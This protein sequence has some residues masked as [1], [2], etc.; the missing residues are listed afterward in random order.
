MT[1]N[2]QFLGWSPA[3]L[4]N[5]VLS[6]SAERS[7]IGQHDIALWRGTDGIARAWENRCPHRGMRLSFGIVRENTLT[8]LYHG[9]R[10]KGDGA[11]D[12]IP[13]HPDLEPPNSICAKTYGCAEAGGLIWV[14][15]EDSVADAPKIDGTW[16]PCRSLHLAD[17]PT[18]ADVLR[19][20]DVAPLGDHAA[21]ATGPDI[22]DIILALQ[23]MGEK[24]A[25]LH[26]AVADQDH[27]IPVSTWLIARRS[28]LEAGLAA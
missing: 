15:T 3:G 9:W 18:L 24:G 6:G 21:R 1:E 25:M 4:A 14:N 19:G 23:G 5:L 8:C 13:A 16:L 20:L 12:A 22:P 2:A 11:C 17:T 28:E 27:M 10:Y 26:C 7:I